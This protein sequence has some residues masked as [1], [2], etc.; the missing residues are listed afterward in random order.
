MSGESR[1]PPSS[2]WWR[3]A[4]QSAEVLPE[5]GRLHVRVEGR[6]VTV[7]RVKGRLS[8]IDS[9]CHHAGGPLTLGSLQDI[10]D[11]G[12]TVVLCPWHKFMVD[13]N[14]G[15]NAY[16]SLEMVG[17]KLTKTGWKS[18]KMVQ[19]SHAVMEDGQ[20]SLLVRLELSGECSSDGDASSVRCARDIPLHD[21]EPV[22]I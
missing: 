7:F 9:I 19:R 4:E 11:L 17:G 8:A 15:T 16:Q 3:V 12:V 13:V 2:G 10:E 5:G 20:G 1:E 22:V 21:Y 6:F 18:G 14:K